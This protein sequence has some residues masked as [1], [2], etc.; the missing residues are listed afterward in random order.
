MQAHQLTKGGPI[1]CEMGVRPAAKE[2]AGDVI[3]RLKVPGGQCVT[4]SFLKTFFDGLNRL[5]HQLSVAASR[6]E[7]AKDFIDGSLGAGR[8][9]QRPREK[10]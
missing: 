8:R 6:S 7:S 3:D 9:T 10:L 1:G 5:R 2:K 4:V